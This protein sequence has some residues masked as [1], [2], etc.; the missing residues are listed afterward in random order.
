LRRFSQIFCADSRRFIFWS[1]CVCFNDF[2][3][4]RS[5]CLPS[6]ASA[7]KKR[8]SA[9]PLSALICG[10]NSI[11]YRLQPGITIHHILFFSLPKIEIPSI[12]M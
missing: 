8:K 10:K 3:L 5:A 1:S 11:L 7:G 2:H 6:A 9:C 12:F 4:R